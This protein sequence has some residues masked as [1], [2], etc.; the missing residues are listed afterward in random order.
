MNIR[1]AIVVLGG[2]SANL[3]LFYLSAPLFLPTFCYQRNLQGNGESLLAQWPFG[4]VVAFL[5]SLACAIVVVRLSKGRRPGAVVGIAAGVFVLAALI[6]H[7]TLH[8]V[9]GLEFFM[10]TP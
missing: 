10:L 2:G 4:Y 6:A 1:A 9:L 8:F 3:G 7:V 5:Y